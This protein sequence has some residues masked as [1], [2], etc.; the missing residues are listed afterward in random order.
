MQFQ[1]LVDVYEQLEQTSGGN[2]IREI[3]AKF[4]KEA[5][6]EDVP[7]LAYLTLGQLAAEYQSAVLGLAEK[8]V[9]KSISVA[10][11]TD[12]KYVKTAL[13]ETGDAGLAAEKILRKKPMTLVPLGKLTVHELFDKLRLIA[14]TSG[15]GSIDTKTKTIATLLQKASPTGA[16]YV[17]RIA[18]GTLRMGV[19]DM[20]VLDALAIAFTGDKKNKE[21]LEKAYNICPDVGK[22]A[23]TLVEEGLEGLEK[24]QIE[25]GRPIKMMAAQRVQNLE[26]IRKK[27]D[28]AMSVEGK[29]DGERIQVHSKD[30]VS[31]FSRRLDNISDQ[32]PD[33][34]KY[35]AN[36]KAK[37]FIIE[38]EVM[39]VDENGNHLPFQVLMQRRR[40]H[41]IEEY[42]KKIPVEFKVFDL[43]YVDGS[44]YMD[45]PYEERMK[46]L[47][48]MIPKN[49]HLFLADQIVT[50]NLDDVEEFFNKMVE[51][52]Q[53]GIMIKSLKGEY[54]AGMRGWNWIKWK[55]DYMSVTDTFD[56]AIVGAFYGRG[57]RS[58]VYGALL[59]ACYNKKED[60]FETV[61]KV[62]TGLT[63]EMLASLPKMLKKYETKKKPSRL[64]CKK[65]VEPDVW[66]EPG[67]VIEVLAAE[68]TKSPYHTLGYALRFPR[69][70]KVRDDKGVSEVTTSKEIE[71]MAQ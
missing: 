58:G 42:V 39:A 43:L 46:K 9:L 55:K 67:I 70:V 60:S 21:V 1:K 28:G 26:D 22:V 7:M 27:I 19:G 4:F 51:D 31:L 16:K 25:V 56:L 12:I 32:F 13:R 5:N 24:I 66:F 11:G 8:S 30:I 18:L 20:A 65:E 63:D 15:L 62:G 54:Q 64:K 69:F 47:S 52:G 48:T 23:Q 41:D 71:A 68:I 36:V 37:E 38:G 35:L 45:K 33:L 2:D 50:D 3:L 6:K 40:K 44:T 29:Y 17:I 53:E 59:C 34:V 61:C 10:G 57:K 14:K 49:E